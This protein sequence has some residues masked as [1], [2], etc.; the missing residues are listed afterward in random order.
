MLLDNG[1]LKYVVFANN[2]FLFFP[3]TVEYTAVKSLYSNVVI[4]GAGY[5]SFEEGQFRCYGRSESLG[6]S[7]RGREDELV[8]RL[9]I[10]TTNYI[11]DIINRGSR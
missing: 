2:D 11:Q 9:G 5:V 8:I 7:S 6:V 3:G 1:K 4:V 10:R